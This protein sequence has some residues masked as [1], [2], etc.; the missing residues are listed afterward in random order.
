MEAINKIDNI[1][2]YVCVKGGY[3]KE[4]TKGWN[5]DVKWKDRGEVLVGEKILLQNINN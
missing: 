2:K 1:L 5:Y 4:F 3:N